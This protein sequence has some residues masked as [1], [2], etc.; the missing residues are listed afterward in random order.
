MKWRGKPEK[1]R[2]VEGPQQ[3]GQQHKW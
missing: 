2:N 1:E 3:H